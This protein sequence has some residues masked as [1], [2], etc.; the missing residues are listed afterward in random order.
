MRVGGLALLLAGLRQ[1]D[2]VH[3]PG[4][5]R[6]RPDDAALVG[7]LLDRGRRDPRRPDPVAAHHDR[8]LLAV[9]VEVGGAERLRVAGAE[10]EDVADL[11]RRLDLDRAAAGGRVAG[12]DRA[13]V[14]L[15]GLEVAGGVDAAQVGVGLVGAAD[16]GVAGD[17]R[18]HD[19]RQPGADRPD[20]ADRPE[21]GLDLLG[22]GLAEVGAHPVAQLDL[23]EPVVA[24]QEDEHQAAALDDD[25]HRLDQGSGGD[26]QRAGDLLDGGQPRRL[27]P[28]GG[29]GSG[30]GSST[31]CGSAEATSTLAA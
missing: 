10:L 21:L 15:V 22:L 23:V 11:D 26:A 14:H 13:H 17:R 1:R 16:V 9:L 27:D 28:L 20:V 3:A 25:R 6:R 12:L 7:A 5:D 19:D 18:V 4:R 29:V 8:P 30:A 31:G 24:A 2:Q